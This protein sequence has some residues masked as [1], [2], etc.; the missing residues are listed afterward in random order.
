MLNA[1]NPLPVPGVLAWADL[2][3]A[4][5]VWALPL[6]PRLA[7]GADGIPEISL[8]LYRRGAGN[9]PEGGQLSL[10]V[11]LKLTPGEREAAAKAGVARRPPPKP[12]APQ[13]PP[14]EVRTPQWVAATVRAELLPTLSVA[15][16]PS[17]LGDNACVLA[18]QLDA[19]RAAAVQDA[20][21]D[22]FPDAT[23][24]FDGSVE[25]ANAAAA[26][27]TA[28]TQAPNM[29]FMVAAAARSAVQ[30]PLLLRGPLILPPGAI[31]ARRTDLTL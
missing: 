28:A 20:W 1:A 27:A 5:T 4:D 26:A 9:P 6:R 29:A 8:L 11:D 24:E 21:A 3:T 12:G 22:G 2:D 30:V 19:A 18:V 13:L 17:L 25:G 7:V 23:V 15:G 10:T 31:R 14:V 16:T